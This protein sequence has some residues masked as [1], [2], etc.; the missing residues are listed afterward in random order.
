MVLPI[1]HCGFDELN[2]SDQPNV[3]DTL[4][5]ILGRPRCL[6][7]HVG[8]AIRLDSVRRQIGCPAALLQ[9]SD[10]FRSQVYAHVTQLVQN[11]LYALKKRTEKTHNQRL[12]NL[13]PSN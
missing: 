7:V 12:Q 11:S 8:E 9:Q 13:V 6:T 10:I 1:W 4:S 3:R 5:R 2:P